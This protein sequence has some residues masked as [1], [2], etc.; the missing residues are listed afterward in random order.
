LFMRELHLL[1]KEY[2]Q[3]FSNYLRLN[4]EPKFG[5]DHDK[6]MAH[7]WKLVSDKPDGDLYFIHIA[8]TIRELRDMIGMTWI[9]G[10][11]V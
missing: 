8:A 11:C 6:L 4:Y 7:L 5:T 9:I 3:D 2:G 10:E 1:C